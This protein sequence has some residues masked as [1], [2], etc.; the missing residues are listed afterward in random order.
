MSLRSLLDAVARR[1]RFRR[2]EGFPAQLER[3]LRAEDPVSLR[4]SALERSLTMNDLAAQRVA[5]A[6]ESP[7]QR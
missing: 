1:L 3:A 4:A 6:T 2:R 7:N 5:G